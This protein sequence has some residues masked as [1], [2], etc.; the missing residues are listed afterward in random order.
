MNLNNSDMFHATMHAGSH[1][2]IT[3]VAPSMH[4]GIKHV[5]IVEIHMLILNLCVCVKRHNVF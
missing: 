4:C 1:D 5:T 3:M 2:F